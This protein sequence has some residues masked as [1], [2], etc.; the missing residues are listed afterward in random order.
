MGLNLGPDDVLV[1]KAIYFAHRLDVTD[2][3]DAL[4]AT[5]IE[6][7]LSQQV[8]QALVKAGGWEKEF[9]VRDKSAMAL[10]KEDANPRDYLASLI[11]Q[12][13]EAKRILDIA[14]EAMHGAP[15]D[16]DRVDRW[17]VATLIWERLSEKV[18][19]QA[20]KVHRIELEVKQSNRWLEEFTATKNILSAHYQGQ[21]PHYDMICEVAADSFIRMRRIRASGRDA[22]GR[23][24]LDLQTMFNN[25]IKR[26]Q[27]YTESQKTEFV[28]AAVDKACKQL[29]SVIEPIMRQAAPDAWRHASKEV[30]KVLKG[31]KAA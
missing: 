10:V 26:L 2:W 22:T 14:V 11:L 5:A 17:K 9:Q 18:Q 20:E 24:V 4:V 13:G 3:R 12:Q 31:G 21:G 7:K 30:F 29:I 25:N 15:Q 28:N 8:V 16:V 27:Q 19:E 6:S 23:E 1:T